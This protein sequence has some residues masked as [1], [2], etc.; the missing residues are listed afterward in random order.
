M[1]RTLHIHVNCVFDVV[2]EPP[3]LAAVVELAARAIAERMATQTGCDA[4]VY[5][6]GALARCSIVS[7][8]HPAL[9]KAVA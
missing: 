1:R 2:D 5:E 4:H 9:E 8:T 7:Q 3:S 6:P